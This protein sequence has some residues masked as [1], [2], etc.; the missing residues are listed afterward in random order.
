MTPIS[1]TV[2][3]DYVCPWC[4][5]GLGELETVSKDYALKIDWRPYM[6][7]PD[8]PE[9]GWELPE[10]FRKSHEDPNNPLYQRA[11]ALGLPLKPRTQVPNSR[12]AHECTE[13]AR[14]AGKEQAFHHA[15]IERYW[16]HADDIHDW[17][18]L[19]SA[20]RTAGI[21]PTAMR[22]EVEAGKW[23]A[24]VEESVAAAH[25]LGVNAVPTFILGNKFAIQGAQEARVF[26]Q[27]IE[28][29]QSGV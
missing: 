13:Y 23:K 10:R 2:W 12:R 16:S 22:A 11:K 9:E 8:A 7:R 4:Y 24:A 19:E 28:R 20:A 25:E 5:I 1:I 21:D 6:L 27:A 29:L 18:V 3:S 15:V 14:G 26:R 17:A